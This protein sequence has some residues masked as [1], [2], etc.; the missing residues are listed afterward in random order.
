MTDTIN[1]TEG[2]VG[3]FVG[4]SAL[5]AIDTLNDALDVKTPAALT[6]DLNRLKENHDRIFAELKE[7]PPISEIVP[8]AVATGE[9]LLNG[10]NASTLTAAVT[11]NDIH[12]GSI[13]EAAYEKQARSTIVKHLPALF[14]TWA[15]PVAA[16]WEAITKAKHE[17]P[18][19]S[20]RDREAPA[21]LTPT[22]FKTWA[23]GHAAVKTL[24]VVLDHA[25]KLYALTPIG[26][27]VQHR[28]GLILAPLT[29][30]QLQQLSEQRHTPD[31]RNRYIR[32]IEDIEGIQV[33]LADPDEFKNRLNALKEQRSARA[34]AQAE[35][36][37]EARR[38]DTATPFNESARQAFA[39]LNQ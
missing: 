16:A 14:K 8:Q 36:E 29:L 4:R 24:D 30:E 39:R 23:P 37:R 38:R 27:P 12:I 1:K 3:S 35:Q 18:G 7:Q 21:G 19:V 6:K 2:L 28:K 32:R 10:P 31:A 13:V 17:L 26:A 33:S 34:Y 22:Q 11:F 15:K 20:L 5:S 9:S 25:G